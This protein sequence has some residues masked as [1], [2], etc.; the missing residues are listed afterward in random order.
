MKPFYEASTVSIRKDN[1]FLPTE[2]LND[3]QKKTLDKM[4]KEI[5]ADKV[6]H[7]KLTSSKWEMIFEDS[8]PGP[9]NNAPFKKMVK[10][11]S[12]KQNVFIIIRAKVSEQ[13]VIYGGY[14]S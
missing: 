2:I 14:T 4:F 8:A 10:A 1:F 9:G 12:N 3:K 6:D 7:K 13:E 11:V 5:T